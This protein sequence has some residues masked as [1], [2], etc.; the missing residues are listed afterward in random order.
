M[1]LAKKRQGGSDV[2]VTMG[3][4]SLEWKKEAE[5]KEYKEHL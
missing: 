4:M 5:A 1:S 3:G 2:L